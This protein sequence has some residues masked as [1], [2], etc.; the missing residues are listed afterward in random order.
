MIAIGILYALVGILYL[1][2]F[3]RSR[4]TERHEEILKNSE[5]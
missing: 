3:K 1:L 4:K 5:K 2:H